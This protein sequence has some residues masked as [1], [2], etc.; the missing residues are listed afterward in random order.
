MKTR[1]L[2]VLVA[3]L[4]IAY[5]NVLA[6]EAHHP[7]N[8][9][10]S[11][12]TSMG[13]MSGGAMMD[14]KM[15]ERMQENMQKMQAQMKE[16]HDT[17]DDDTRDRLM[18]EHMQAM[19]EGMGMMRGMGGDMM[20]G[21]KNGGVQ[22]R[23]GMEGGMMKNAK[24]VKDDMAPKSSDMME[25]MGMMEKRMDMMQMMMEQQLESRKVERRHDHRKMK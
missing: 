8:A 16:I 24:S 9:A 15:M 7:D 4:A 23:K 13:M 17:K 20:Q 2:A 25:R 19:D 3:A 12:S 22:Q 21:M 11:Q 18:N 5:G 10:I 6:E 1:N 14:D